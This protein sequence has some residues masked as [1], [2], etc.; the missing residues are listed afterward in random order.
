MQIAT[1]IIGLIVELSYYALY[2]LFV[3]VAIRIRAL[4]LTN[5]KGE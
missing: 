3:S 4:N 1:A 2:I 5:K